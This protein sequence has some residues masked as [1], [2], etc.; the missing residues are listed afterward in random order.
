MV[1]EQMA[2]WELLL[3]RYM[4]VV[5]TSKELSQNS[6]LVC[7]YTSLNAQTGI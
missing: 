7:D 5:E 4:K 3:R 6:F 2:L 1:E